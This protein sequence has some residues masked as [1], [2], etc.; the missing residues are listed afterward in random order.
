MVFDNIICCFTSYYIAKYLR[1]DKLC[2]TAFHGEVVAFMFANMDRQPRHANM[3]PLQDPWV[4][5]TCEVRR[6]CTERCLAEAS[7]MK[8]GPPLFII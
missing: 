5:P 6:W 4:A 3:F 7:H 1:F 8:Y 2:Y